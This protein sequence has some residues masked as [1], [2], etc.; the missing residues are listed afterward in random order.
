MR[1]LRRQA[2]ISQSVDTAPAAAMMWSL[3]IWP[4]SQI[5]AAQP[6]IGGIPITWRNI[7]DCK[8]TV[9]QRNNTRI[10]GATETVDPRRCEHFRAT[11]S[12]DFDESAGDAV[13]SLQVGGGYVAVRQNRELSSRLAETT[14]SIPELP[15]RDEADIISAIVAIDLDRGGNVVCLLAVGQDGKFISGQRCD[16]DAHRVTRRA[17]QIRLAAEN[18]IVTETA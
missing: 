7:G 5:D 9:L 13:S 10:G 2:T 4:L 6:E 1:P 17:R 12:F 15:L 14:R 8:A 16:I 18:L 3:A 11:C